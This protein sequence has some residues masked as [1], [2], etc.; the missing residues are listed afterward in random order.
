MLALADFTGP[1]QPEWTTNEKFQQIQQAT[2]GLD[3]LNRILRARPHHANYYG[4]SV[5]P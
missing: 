5:D 1:P 3:W 2:P 4:Q